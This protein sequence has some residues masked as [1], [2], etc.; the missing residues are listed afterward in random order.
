MTTK[1]DLIA[2]CKA[3]NPKIVSMINGEEIELIGAE[4]DKACNDWAEMR[5]IQ[6]AKDAQDA[7]EQATKEAA[8]AKLAALGLTEADLIAI[9]LLPKPELTAQ[10]ETSPK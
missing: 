7:A 2:Q 1:S 10:N 3:E 5:L 9:G 8:Q 6:I 4:Y